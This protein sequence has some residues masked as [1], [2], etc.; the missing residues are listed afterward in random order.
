MDNY[1]YPLGADTKDAPWNQHD[2]QELEFE[3]TISQSLSKSTTVTTTDYVEEEDYDDCLEQN[4]PVS[5]TDDT[6]WM[7][8][9]ED[10]HYTPY[11][12]II[13]LK[14]I[15]TTGKL[16]SEKERKY[17]IQ[18]CDNWDIDETEVCQ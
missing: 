12:L 18:E 7:C 8:A 11:N 3:V 4:I 13:L 5:N 17:L 16:P 14:D 10:C 1:N 15:L 9:Y 6:N 2:P